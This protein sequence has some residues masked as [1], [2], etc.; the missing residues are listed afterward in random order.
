M[1]PRLTIQPHLERHIEPSVEP[2]QKQAREAWDRLNERSI[3]RSPFTDWAVMSELSRA[4]GWKQRVVFWGDEMAVCFF[5]RRRAVAR[6]IVVPPFSP[7]TAV[8]LSADVPPE[9]RNALLSRVFEPIK[10]L[11]DSRL[12]SFEPRL[13]G[14]SSS[15]PGYEKRQM[16]TYWVSCE[17]TS[18]STA[19]YSENTRRVLK[20]SVG[21]YKVVVNSL[22]VDQV[23]TLVGAGYRSHGRSAPL[24]DAKLASLATAICGGTSTAKQIGVVNTTSGSLEAGI[25]FL[26]HDKMAWY[27]FAG[28]VRGP[29][30]TVLIDASLPE[31]SAMGVTTLDF[32]GANT[33]GIAEFKRKFGGELVEY[34]H[35]SKSSG[36]NKMI[37]SVSRLLRNK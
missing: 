7:Y 16:K 22:P 14:F 17:P 1:I 19:S 28:S 26:I 24:Y 4:F 23:A 10:G 8:A 3:V 20:K 21:D 29:A 18:G 34:A 31:L 35:F 15:N 6:D 33:P 11:P 5:E 32:M 12:I 27:W 2:R 25:V 9:S 30:M 36:L 37:S 13:S